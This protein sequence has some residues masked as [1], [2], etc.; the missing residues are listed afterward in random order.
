MLDDLRRGATFLLYQ[1]ALAVGIV[2]MPVAL[3]ARR[4]GLTL[5]IGRLVETAERAY[6]S[7]SP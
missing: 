7:A 6:R 3:G 4:L 1:I 2:A 5:P